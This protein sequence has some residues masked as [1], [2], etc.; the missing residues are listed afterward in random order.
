MKILGKITLGLAL[1][2]TLLLVNP[3][4]I[5]VSATENT[6]TESDTPAVEDD[7]VIQIAGITYEIST[8]YIDSEIPAGYTEEKMEIRGEKVTV[9]KGDTSGVI[10][11]Y[12]VAPD[13]TVVANEYGYTPKGKFFRYDESTNKF[14]PYV[15]ITVSDTTYIVF[16]TE[17]YEVELPIQYIP[18]TMTADGFDFPAW[19]DTELDGYYLVYAVSSKGVRELYRYDVNDQSYQ[20]FEVPPEPENPNKVP[21]ETLQEI[22]DGIANNLIIVLL[23]IGLILFLLLVLTITFGIKLKNR[24]KEIDDI[25]EE[26]VTAYNH[27]F[28]EGKDKQSEKSRTNKRDYSHDELDSTE[29][30]EEDW[31]D[32]SDVLKV[33]KDMVNEDEGMLDDGMTQEID[34]SMV[35]D[36][37]KNDGFIDYEQS[38]IGLDREQ[39]AYN[40]YNGFEQTRFPKGNATNNLGTYSKY[41]ANDDDDIE[42]IE[43]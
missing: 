9:I 24:N 42:F 8:K 16:L 34:I 39:S 5:E 13:E 28:F 21:N 29:D 4:S 43:I 26:G 40:Q 27:S 6:T 31:D 38:S 32:E 15:Q 14:S 17:D 25:Y 33:L 7:G 2:C 12:L 23:I 3:M 22:I 11:V 20:R 18:T 10:L 30:I 36:I 35:E 41:Q 1:A 37:F 19:Q